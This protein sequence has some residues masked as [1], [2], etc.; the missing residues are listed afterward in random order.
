MKLAATV[1]VAVV[2]EVP[3]TAALAVIMVDVSGFAVVVVVLVLV[4]VVVF[5]V[6]GSEI[7]THGEPSH[8]NRSAGL[9]YVAAW[10]GHPMVTLVSFH[11][12]DNT[13]RLA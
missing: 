4:L 10:Q 5:D 1:V 3:A 13:T 6:G 8:R 7:V 11:L 12:L 2:L 9:G